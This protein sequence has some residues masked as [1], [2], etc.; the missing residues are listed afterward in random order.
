MV[1]YMDW[2]VT[3]GYEQALKAYNDWV[4]GPNPANATGQPLFVN[5]IIGSP[6]VR[7]ESATINRGDPII[8]HVIGANYI[9]GDTDSKGNSIDNDSKIMQACQHSA[10][11]E[12]FVG[13][14]EFKAEQDPNWTN[15]TDAVQEVSMT[16]VNFNADPS[17]PHLNDWDFPMPP[18]E[19]RGAWASKLLL[20]QIPEPGVFEL[21]SH[22]KGIPPF[23]QN[24]YFKIKVQ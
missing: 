10:E 1:N 21:R 5:G 19:H 8:V 6:A 15:L 11:N 24:T 3:S 17:N 14:V 9:L 12:D 22:G 16:P 4:Y 7:E 23:E 20:L 2:V 18:G 13:S